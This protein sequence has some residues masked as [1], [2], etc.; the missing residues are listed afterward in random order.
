MT[1]EGYKGVSLKE[2]VV[3]KLQEKAKDA[4]KTLSSFLEEVLQSCGTGGKE[5]LQKGS[6]ITKTERYE[7][8]IKKVE[9]MH[10]DIKAVREVLEELRR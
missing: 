9:E 4:D 6:T 8:M 10:E 3:E 7:K 2:G 5:V 1:K